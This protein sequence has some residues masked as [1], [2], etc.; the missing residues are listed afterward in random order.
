MFSTMKNP[1]AK[2]KWPPRNS[3]G[4]ICWGTLAP[5]SVPQVA[6]VKAAI[7]A[8]AGSDPKVK[9]INPAAMLD[10]SFVKMSGSMERST[11]GP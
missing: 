9:T 1:T 8:L 5:G 7:D 11:D 3:N 2:K 6:Q 10:Q 4:S